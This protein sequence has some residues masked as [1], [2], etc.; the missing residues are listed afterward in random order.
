MWKSFL[1]TCCMQFQWSYLVYKAHD[2]EL[3]WKFQKVRQRSILT[4][5]SSEIFIWRTSVHTA[6]NSWWVISLT[7]QFDQELLGWKF[8]KVKQMSILNPSEIFAFWQ[9]ACSKRSEKKVNITF[10]WDFDVE[11]IPAKLQHNTCNSWGVI[12]FTRQLDLGASLKVP[13]RFSKVNVKLSGILV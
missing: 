12:A 3:V 1:T 5:N 8:K 6:C 11:K 9:S 13:N 4:S 2:L 10:V 7:R